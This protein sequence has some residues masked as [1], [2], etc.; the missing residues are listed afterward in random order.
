MTP[1]SPDWHVPERSLARFA[2][3]PRGLDVADVASI[4]THLIACAVCRD[5]LRSSADPSVLET[6]WHAIADVVDRPRTG[7]LEQLLGRVGFPAGPSRLITATAG[8]RVAGVLSVAV[9]AT[10]A[11]VASRLAE[12][13]GPFLVVAPMA[14][15]VAVA[16]SFAAASEPAGEAAVA[17]PMWGAALVLRRT[18]GVLVTTFGILGIASAA[19]PDLDVRAMGWILPGVALSVLALA[20]ATWVRAE[21]GVP[22][23]TTAWLALLF[24]TRWLAGHDAALVDSPVFGPIG[25]L[26]AFATASVA[27][28]VVLSRRSRFATLE[29][30]R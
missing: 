24:G 27:A 29:S 23:L 6:S 13:D 21:V 10:L 2:H 14:P 22:M 19:L 1:P 11:A 5:R 17:S 9:V 26:A 12:A 20:L 3:D 30:F 7:W 4:E 16:L 25:Q 15:L 18:V 28:V 8:L